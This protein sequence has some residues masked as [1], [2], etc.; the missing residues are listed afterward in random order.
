MHPA[1][2]RYPRRRA[3]P[4]LFLVLSLSLAACEG[5]AGANGLTGPVGPQGP[6]G[7]TGPQGPQGPVGSNVGRTIYG[8]DSDNKL[9]A[10][11][12]LRPDIVFNSPTVSG[13][14]PGEK[15]EGIDFR[16]ADSI[17]YALGSSGRVYTLNLTSGAATAVGTTPFATLT[18]TA[19]GWDFNPTVDRIRIH[20]DQEQNL[21]VVPTT[22]A[23]AATDGALAYGVGDV[24]FGSNPSIVGTAYTNSFVGA[25]TTT[26]YAIDAAR[27]ALV[28]VNPPNN[29]TLI[30]VGSLGTAT[31][32]DVGFDIAGNNGTAYATLTSIAG[33]PSTLYVVNLSTGTLFPVG[34]VANA[35]PL[36]GIAVSP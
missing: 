3:I 25:T 5:P 26:L 12:A 31:T 35:K 20:T 8:I 15:I 36:R 27:A 18:G 28:M 11:G 22:G 24:G 16:P 4:A 33:A 32:V 9:I 13:L 30:T 19:F 34:N 2:S 17:L 23:L 1:D 21:R 29:G 14:Q 7:P 10:F 6:Q